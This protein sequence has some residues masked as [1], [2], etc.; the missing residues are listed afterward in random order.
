MRG[1]IWWSRRFDELVAGARLGCALLPP[2]LSYYPFGIG[3]AAYKVDGFMSRGR[4]SLQRDVWP[5]QELGFYCLRGHLSPAPKL[6][7]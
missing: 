5:A 2:K 6:F 1:A 7:V 4:L 3:C